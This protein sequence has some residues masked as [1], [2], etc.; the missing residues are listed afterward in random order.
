MVR[1]TRIFL[2]KALIKLGKEEH[3]LRYIEEGELRFSTAMEFSHMKE[4]DNK[5]ADKN[6]GSIF[7]DIKDLY[8]A[9]LI[10]DNDSEIIY[11]KPFKLA[12]NASARFTTPYIQRIPFHCLYVYQRPPINEVV[13]L[14]NYEQI[15]NDFPSYDMAVVI[16][17][18]LE[19][20]KRLESKFEIY[21]DYVTYTDSTPC[22][23]DIKNRI[24]YLYYKREQYKDQNEFRI[25]LPQINIESP[26]IYRIGSLLD[27]AYCLPLKCLKTGVI[28]ADNDDDFSNLKRRCLDA[29]YN[30]GE[31]ERFYND[32]RYSI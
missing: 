13:K 12:D 16:Y 2:P 14:D 27:I 5:I 3:M 23:E 31:K 9:E 7:H 22:E 20:L 28:I 18:P 1:D 26:E 11:G 17:N 25:S 4:G 8:A 10:V 21:A 24:R 15:C 32:G 29:G 6:E 19:F 30:V